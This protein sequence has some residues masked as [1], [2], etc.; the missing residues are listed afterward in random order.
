MENVI[1]D[2][3]F[4]K[5]SED[6][7]KNKKHIGNGMFVYTCR[8][9]HKNGKICGKIVY[10]DVSNQKYHTGFAGII[11]Y[12]TLKNHKYAH[13]CCKRHLNRYNPYYSSN[14]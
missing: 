7:R 5:A 4:D 2:I 13:K 3:D 6:W 11:N 10:K 9:Q 1:I 14:Q 12:D 8:Y